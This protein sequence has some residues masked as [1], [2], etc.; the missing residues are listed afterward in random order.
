MCSL[1]ISTVALPFLPENMFLEG[2]GVDL[3]ENEKFLLS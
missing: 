3:R 2:E 1:F